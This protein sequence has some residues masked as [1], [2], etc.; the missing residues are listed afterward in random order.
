MIL[1]FVLD[2]SDIFAGIIEA[3]GGDGNGEE[4]GCGEESIGRDAL[5][6]RRDEERGR[7]YVY[8][9]VPSFG[10]VIWTVPLATTTE[11][12]SW[13]IRTLYYSSST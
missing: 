7:E 12:R 4:L 11:P 3:E 5:G 8:F 1:L 13:N 9:H 6:C 10:Y 2:G